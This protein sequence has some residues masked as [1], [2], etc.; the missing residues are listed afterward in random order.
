MLID[1][2]AQWFIYLLLPQ[3]CLTVLI[4]K[5]VRLHGMLSFQNKHIC[6]AI[7]G[8]QCESF[9]SHLQVRMNEPEMYYFYSELP[10]PAKGTN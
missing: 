3:F 2:E 8:P 4:S 1:R 10:D 6:L 7:Y 9:M 5:F